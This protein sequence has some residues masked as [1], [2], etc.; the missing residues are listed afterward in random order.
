MIQTSLRRFSRSPRT[1]VY[2]ATLLIFA[3]LCIVD[4]LS[5]VSAR[6]H[7]NLPA[8]APNVR[9][10]KIFIA[11]IHW[12]NEP[13][14]RSN[15]NLAVLNLVDYFGAENVYVSVYESGSW[16]DS[17]EALRA[18]DIDLERKGVRRT[19]KLN[20]TTHAD[21]L[22]QPAADGWIQTPRGRKELRRIPY[23]SKLRNLALEPLNHL[24]DGSKFDKVLFLN[25]VVFTTEDVTT[26]LA[27]RD[28]DYSAACSLDF[29]KPPHYYDTFALRD[30][31]GHEAVTSTFPY[32]RSE[33]SRSAMISGHPVPVQSC[34]NGIVAFD[35]APFYAPDGLEFRGVPDSLALHHVEGSECC[36]IHV[37]NP[38]TQSHGVW[39]NP[40][41]RVGYSPDAYVTVK[42][43]SAWPSISQSLV[44]IWSNRLWRWTTTPKIK[45]ARITSI[46]KSWSKG[47]PDRSEPGKFCLI[48]EMQVLIENGWAHV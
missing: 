7:Q 22:K 45:T 13:I 32:F 20:E 46:L 33:A 42:S 17:K 47:G 48:N 23:L 40:N 34:W 36:L 21:E 10:Q 35:A 37:D 19:V 11:S 31:D 44:G 30:K 18:L 6:Q 14:L 27:T 38:L 9:G 1:R 8:K 43:A 25:D 39:L 3:L 24:E 16:D 5:L 29:A 15:W 28:G 2:R 4:I 41:V 12:N 26:L